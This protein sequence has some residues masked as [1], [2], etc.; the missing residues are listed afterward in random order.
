MQNLELIDLKALSRAQRGDKP[1]P[2]ILIPQLIKSEYKRDLLEGFPVVPTRGSFP[3]TA[4][5]GSSRFQQL[6]E[7]L[8][9][10]SFRDAVADAFDIDLSE[11]F[12]ML[13]VRGYTG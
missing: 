3:A 9:S 6:S 7:E 4:V 8:Q 13:T 2:H 5:E 12:P 1:Y 11:R 10:D